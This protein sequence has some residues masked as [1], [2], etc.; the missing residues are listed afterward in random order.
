MPGLLLEAGLEALGSAGTTFI[1][2]PGDPDFEDHRRIWRSVRSLAIANG[3]PEHDW[4]RALAVLD[5]NNTVL[6]GSTLIAAWGR[7]SPATEIAA[8][9]PAP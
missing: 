5:S 9:V 7:K 8:R 4:D 3:M 2:R 1:S 6:V